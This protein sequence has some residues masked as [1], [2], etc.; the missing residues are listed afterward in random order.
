[1]QQCAQI[2]KNAGGIGLAVHCIRAA[3]SY[4]RGSNGNSN[5]LVPMLRVFNHTARY[6]DQGG[7]KRKGSFAIYLEPWH[8]DVFA[9][10]DLKKNHGAEE[11]RARD[12]F[13][14][15]WIN[16]LFMV[17]VEQDGDWSLFC[18]HE[19][20]GLAEV[21]GVEFEKLYTQYERNGKARKVVK[22]RTLWQAIL[23][24]QIETGTPYVL[25]KDACNEKSNQKNLGTI[26]CSN[27]CTEIVEYT[28]PDEVAV[29]N[30][31]SLALP[32]FVVDGKFN[33][34]LL[35]KIV[36]VVTRNLNR[37]IDVNYYPVKE[38]ER[39][40][41]RHRPIGLG[42]QGLADAFIKL[43]LPFDSV[44]AQQVNKEIFETIYFA[45]LS[46]SAELAEEEGAYETY[47]GSPVS[48]GTLSAVARE[49][50][51]LHF[52]F[53]KH[54]AHRALTCLALLRYSA[55]RH[56]GCVT[57]ASMGLEL[58]SRQDPCVGCA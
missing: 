26:R 23:Q 56:V 28:S 46:A 50:S 52:P 42:V 22:A 20:P 58:S 16:D 40:N 43:R 47:K 1:M 31:A 55:V 14:A 45:A 27:L 25:Y 39:S 6:V 13:F 37:I 18:P 32:A 10:L 57:H 54:L 12:L 44:E 53:P 36:R 29:C 51:I 35:Y 34:E 8:A 15:L 41:K 30:L 38:A 5:G 33:H 2:S 17:R 3:G 4:V 11:E 21:Y 9:F 7:G 19:C 48:Q 49:P 24:S